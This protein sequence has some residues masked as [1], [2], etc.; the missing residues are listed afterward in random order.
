M[1]LGGLALAVG[2]LVDDATV[3]IENINRLLPEGMPLRETILTGAQQIAAPAFVATLSICIV[4]VP[5]LFLKGVPGFLFRPLA[6]AV[7]FAMLASYFLS[8]TLVPTLVMYFFRAERSKARGARRGSEQPGIV[9]AASTWVLKRASSSMRDR[10]VRL[11][12]LVPA[13][14][15][16]IRR[17]VSGVLRG[18]HGSGPV[19]RLRL[20]PTVD[21]GQ[22][23]LHLRA[24]IGTRVEETAALCDRVEQS[25]PPADSDGRSCRDPRQHR[26]PHTAAS[27]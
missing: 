25:H 18:H 17:A 8:R 26:I 5:I 24:P 6:E 19:P 1:T 10:Y 12:R 7:V 14:S 4:F 20:F 9:P 21:A 23:R 15:A 13:A 3:E 16:G 27:T 11:A 2:I 22:I